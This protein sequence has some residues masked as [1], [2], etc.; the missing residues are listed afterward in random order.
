MYGE[1]ARIGLIVPASNT[2][3][4]PELARLCPEGVVT[5]AT[6]IMFEPTISGLKAMKDHVHRAGQELSSENICQLIVFCCTVGSMIDG[7]DSDLALADS[8]TEATGT[9]AITVTSA[10]KAAFTALGVRRLAL[11]T[12]YTREITL[13]EK[14][15]LEADGYRITRAVS[16]HDQLPP[17]DLRNDMIGRLSPRDAYGLALQADGEDNEAVFISCTNL[18]T[19]E[20]ISDLESRINKPVITSN[21]ATMWHALRTLGLTD[22]HNGNGVL[23]SEH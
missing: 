1:R 23:L 20:I 21:Q 19:L 14:D 13:K 17:Q 2:V 16:Y 4:E 22:K 10:V 12:P 15:I 11:V 9:P 3:C 6:R 5:L 18:R 7:G 8:I